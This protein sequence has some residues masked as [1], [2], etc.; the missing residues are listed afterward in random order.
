ML[1]GRTY[2]DEFRAEA[3]ALYRRTDRSVTKVADDLGVNHH[4][5]RYWL[6]LDAMSRRSGRLGRPRP[7]QVRVHLELRI[8][9]G[10]PPCR[11]SAVAK[12]RRMRFIRARPLVAESF[13]CP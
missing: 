3:V 5:L 7:L 6:K 4:T 11:T 12:S 13:S 10:V 2:T 8:R 9:Q 1:R